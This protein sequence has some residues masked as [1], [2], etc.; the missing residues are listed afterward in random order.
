MELLGIKTYISKET[1]YGDWSCT[2]YKTDENPKELIDRIATYNEDDGERITAELGEL[3]EIGEFCAD[4]GMVAVFLLDEVLQYNPEFFKWVD[5][6]K[7]CVTK[8]DNFDGEIEYYVDQ[9]DNAHIYGVG[10]IN[11]AT[12]QTG[13]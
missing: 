9:N 2:T 3:D 8:I 4:A 5:E 1:L 11:F 12:F 13:L 6:H 7:W 10:N